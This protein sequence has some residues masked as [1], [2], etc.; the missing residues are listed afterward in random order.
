V[1]LSASG[2][3]RNSANILGTSL[4][5]IGDAFGAENVPC[6]R[7]LNGA[8]WTIRNVPPILIWIKLK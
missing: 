6:D 5:I 3:D 4:R 2:R 8:P 1:T 7:G